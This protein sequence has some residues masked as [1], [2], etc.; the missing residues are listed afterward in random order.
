MRCLR[1]TSSWTTSTSAASASVSSSDSTSSCT[2]RNGTHT[3]V[4]CVRGHQ[5]PT[6]SAVVQHAGAASCCSIPSRIQPGMIVPGACPNLLL[7]AVSSSLAAAPFALADI[8]APLFIHTI[9]CTMAMHSLR[10]AVSCSVQKRGCPCPPAGVI[11]TWFIPYL[12]QTV[13]SS[14]PTCTGQPLQS[15][16]CPVCFCRHDLHKVC[17]L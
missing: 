2:S 6:G 11:C 14:L 15:S 3:L 10:P 17:A 16:A 8:D 13:C 4:S 1:S 9:V 5:H 7:Q 12:G